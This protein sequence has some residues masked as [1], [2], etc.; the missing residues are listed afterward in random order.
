ME[1]ASFPRPDSFAHHESLRLP[2]SAV[3]QKLVEIIGRKLT[4]YVGGVKDA[5]SLIHIWKTRKPERRRMTTRHR[6]PG[7]AAME[8]RRLAAGER[9]ISN[10]R[11]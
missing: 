5:L 4:A 3:V 1:T 6:R 7:T 10:T 2:A 11:S 8:Q 9:W